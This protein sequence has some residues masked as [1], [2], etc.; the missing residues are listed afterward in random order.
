MKNWVIS[1]VIVF[2]GGGS[3]F[4]TVAPQT[5]FA[6]DNPTCA[7]RFLGFP[8]WYRGL[9]DASDSCIIKSPSELNTAASGDSENGLQK[10]ILII[11]L[12]IIEA[13]MMLAGY[14]AVFFV[15]YGGFQY[16]TSQGDSGGA[17]KARTTITNA[18]I[19]LMISIAA[20]AIVNFIFA[21]LKI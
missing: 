10:F 13:A 12:N 5:V 1:L 3:L 7:G 11:A 4:V 16:L 9:T 2:I 20:V 15:L 17:V 18:V 6:A 14:I 19:G 8:V 21:G